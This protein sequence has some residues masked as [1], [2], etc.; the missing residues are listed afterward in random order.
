MQ[1]RKIKQLTPEEWNDLS[2]ELKR[3]H[4]DYT[5]HIYRTYVKFSFENLDILV[6]FTGEFKHIATPGNI[7]SQFSQQ[8]K[9]HKINEGYGRR[10]VKTLNGKTKVIW[11]YAGNNGY[12]YANDYYA[13]KELRCWSYD[14]SSAYAFAMLNPMPDTTKE[15]RY[16]DRVKKYEMGFYKNG[17]A[18]TVEG[19][20]AD[21]IFPLMDSPFKDWVYKYYKK[22]VDT[23]KIEDEKLR[24]IERQKWKD[25]LNIPQ[26]LLQRYNIFLRNAILYYN[27]IYIRK[28]T[29]ENTVYVN[30]DSIV[31]LVPRPDIPLGDEIGQFKLAKEN[32]SFKYKDVGIFQW[33]DECHYKGIPGSTISD[34]SNVEGWLDN[35]EYRME[36]DLVVKNEKKKR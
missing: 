8:V 2:Y 22:K 20:Y 3:L 25:Y 14:I 19:S 5:K 13:N 26:G 10:E 18:T 30:T 36:G 29:D 23:E 11:D 34:I 27:N 6:S 24:K 28:Y 12:Q 1:Y 4:I 7:A 33:R 31:S 21:I 15:P 32:V 9:F 16:N 17:K 35:F